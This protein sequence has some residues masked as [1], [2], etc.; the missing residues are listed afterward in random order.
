M[1][2]PEARFR[3]DLLTPVTHILGYCSLLIDAALMR[4]AR[5]ELE[6]LQSLLNE[7]HRV[8]GVIEE[9]LPRGAVPEHG[10]DYVLLA[11][12]LSGPSNAIVLGCLR[13]ESLCSDILDQ[14]GR[15]SLDDL[16]QIKGASQRLIELANR[17]PFG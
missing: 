12:R 16:L 6:G 15:E 13:L 5:E 11:S 9:I 7:G 3:H 2:D 4:D 14:E 8:L 1:I 17:G 10:F